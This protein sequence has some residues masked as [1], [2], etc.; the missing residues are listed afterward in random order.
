MHVGRI[1]CLNLFDL[2]QNIGNEA[3]WLLSYFYLR[4][5]EQ[6][7]KEITMLIFNILLVKKMTI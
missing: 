5:N 3:E 2:K 1:K 7:L 6:I 4:K